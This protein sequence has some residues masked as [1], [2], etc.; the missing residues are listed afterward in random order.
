MLQYLVSQG[1]VVTVNDNWA[2]RW[3]ARHGH[4]EMVQ[5]LVSQGA[6]LPN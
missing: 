4:L 3:A 5:Y 6:V 2:V 1:A